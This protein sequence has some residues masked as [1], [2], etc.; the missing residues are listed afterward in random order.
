MVL[1]LLNWLKEV[2]T[3]WPLELFVL[4]GSVLEEIIAPIPAPLVMSLAGYLAHQ[5]GQSWI[6]LIFLALLGAIGKTVASCVFYL[7]GNKAEGIIVSKWGRV[8]GLERQ[9][10]DRATQILNKKWWD[11]AALVFLRVLP[12]IPTFIVSLGCGVLRVPLRAFIWTTMLGSFIRNLFMI[13]LGVTGTAYV[14]QFWQDGGAEMAERPLFIFSTLT[15]LVIGCAIALLIK[16]KLGH[17]TD[18]PTK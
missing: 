2:A 7:L 18:H 1:H 11:E 4:V 10:L 14:Q 12:I 13:W 15:G 5:R 9:H 17:A 6:F 8:L 16:R 3:F